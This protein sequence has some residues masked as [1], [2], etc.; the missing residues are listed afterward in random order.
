MFDSTKL[1]TVLDRVVAAQTWFRE[2]G[3]DTVNTANNF[4]SRLLCFKP[5]ERL[6]DASGRCLPTKQL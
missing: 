4:D 5:N 6:L 1:L 3:G 2:S